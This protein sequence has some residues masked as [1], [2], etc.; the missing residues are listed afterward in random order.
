MSEGLSGGLP[1]CQE[2][3]RKGCQVVRMPKRPDPRDFRQLPEIAATHAKQVGPSLQ[4]VKPSSHG[5]MLLYLS[6]MAKINA[7]QATLRLPYVWSPK[8]ASSPP[9][10]GVP[11]LQRTS[12]VG[13]SR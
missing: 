8:R 4:T 12:F 1:G 7:S 11:A 9:K 13:V 10:R 3:C 2:A 5:S 6:P